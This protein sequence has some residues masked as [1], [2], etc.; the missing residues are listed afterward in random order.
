MWQQHCKDSSCQLVRFFFKKTWLSRWDL[1]LKTILF[2]SNKVYKDV[3]ANKARGTLP[4]TKKALNAT[5]KCE[6][7]FFLTECLVQKAKFLKKNLTDWHDESLQCCCHTSR[8]RLKL[9]LS[10]TMFTW[11]YLPWDPYKLCWKKKIVFSLKIFY[12]SMCFT[13]NKLYWIEDQ[14]ANVSTRFYTS[15]SLRQ[16]VEPSVTWKRV[17][18]MFDFRNV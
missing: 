18:G 4:M 5:N 10:L 7:I 17:S 13:S 3:K 16:L 11:L 14:L 1:S 8:S 15:V 2:I 12:F 9:S 6:I